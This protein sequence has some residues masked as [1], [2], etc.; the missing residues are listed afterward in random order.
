MRLAVLFVLISILAGCGN[1]EST[2]CEN[3][4]CDGRTCVCEDG[5]VG[6]SCELQAKPKAIRITRVELSELPDEPFESRVWDDDTSTAKANLPDVVLQ[7][8]LGTSQNLTFTSIERFPDT[9]E[10][11]FVFDR[12]MDFK[13]ENIFPELRLTVADLDIP[14]PTPIYSIIVSGYYNPVN[15]FPEIISGEDENG[16]EYVL[17]LEYDP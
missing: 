7:V 2:N 9:D 14:K 11:A 5:Y 16:A 13:I 3:G 8:R 15:G 6:Q 4:A 10:R 17:H 12:N 1:C